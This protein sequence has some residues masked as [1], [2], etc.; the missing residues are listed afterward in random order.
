MRRSTGLLP[1]IVLSACGTLQT[2]A[3]PRMPDA[4]RPNIVVVLVDDLRF[5][6]FRAGGHPYLETPNIDRLASEGALSDDVLAAA[7]PVAQT[8]VTSPPS[9]PAAPAPN[10]SLRPP[11]AVANTGSVAPPTSAPP[12]PSAETR[13]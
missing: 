11:H 1:I 8:A 4:G 7:D 13:N 10:R 3:P 5:D 6:E 9:P 2:P 12:S